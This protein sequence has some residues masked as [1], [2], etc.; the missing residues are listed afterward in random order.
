MNRIAIIGNTVREPETKVT[1]TGKS[2]C[3]F[4]L[5]VNRKKS[6]DG[7][8][9]TDYFDCAAWGKTGEI[10]QTYIHKGKKV[11]V[12]GA[13]QS[14]K[15]T[16]QDG[17]KVVAWSLQVEEMELLSGGPRD[18]EQEEATG[19]AAQEESY[20]PDYGDEELPF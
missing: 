16:N 9:E 17:K 11:A 8:Q 12:T 2:V 5:A 15:Y 13:M 1:K 14:R 10:C 6:A 20:V 18:A 4:T 19:H 3:N 7:T